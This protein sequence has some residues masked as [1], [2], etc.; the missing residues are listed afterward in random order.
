MYFA[1]V[2]KCPCGSATAC[3]GLARPGVVDAAEDVP[4]TPAGATVPRH[5]VQP[6]NGKNLST[7][8]LYAP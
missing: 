1:G 3:V 2:A 5:P 6:R 8:D 7:L 4:R